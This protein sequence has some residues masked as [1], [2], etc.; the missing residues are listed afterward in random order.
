MPGGRCLIPSRPGIMHHVEDYA[1]MTS[2]PSRHTRPDRPR[3]SGRI[4]HAAAALACALVLGGCAGDLNP[5]RDVFVATGVGEAEREAP[6]FIAGTRPGEFAYAPIRSID[7]V[8]NE[9]R[10]EEELV[11]MEDDLRRLQE[12]QAARAAQT[13]RMTLLPDPEPVIVEPLP[14]FDPAIEPA[15]P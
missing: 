8:T 3:Q 10:T 12:S 4:C 7:R 15:R 6:E 1:T 5:V 14:D 2:G 13:R 11:E 9:P